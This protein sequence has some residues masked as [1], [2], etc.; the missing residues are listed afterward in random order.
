MAPTKDEFAANLVR[1]K[2]A[3]LRDA[4]LDAESAGLTVEVPGSV[5]LY[6]EGGTASGSPSDWKIYRRH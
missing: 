4:I 1:E 2:L 5:H 3:H 6:L